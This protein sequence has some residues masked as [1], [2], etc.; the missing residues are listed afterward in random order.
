MF[1]FYATP[2]SRIRLNASFPSSLLTN[3]VNLRL[4]HTDCD[5]H[6]QRKTID[7][8]LAMSSHASQYLRVPQTCQCILDVCKS[9]AAPEV[10]MAFS[11]RIVYPALN[12]RSTFEATNMRNAY[13]HRLGLTVRGSPSTQTH[14]RQ[15]EY[16]ERSKRLS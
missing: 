13:I 14:T 5:T 4:K 11:Q 9:P 8:E 12:D 10:P 7:I 2:T 15:K 1:F 3:S 16:E 6:I